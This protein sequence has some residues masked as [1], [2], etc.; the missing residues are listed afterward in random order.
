MR[1]GNAWEAKSWLA[2]LLLAGPLGGWTLV[3]GGHHDWFGSVGEFKLGN[4]LAIFAGVS[5]AAFGGLVPSGRG[6]GGVRFDVRA[7]LVPRVQ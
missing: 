4:L 7:Q 3:Y 6:V 1:L 2:A 5:L